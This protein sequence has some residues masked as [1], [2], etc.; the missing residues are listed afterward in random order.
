M[1][2]HLCFNVCLTIVFTVQTC[3]S[4][5]KGLEKFVTW[6]YLSVLWCLIWHKG[7]NNVQ[8]FFSNKFLLNT[9]FNSQLSY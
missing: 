6:R 2:S 9:T 3:L 4:K 8:E 1:C 7:I 5:A